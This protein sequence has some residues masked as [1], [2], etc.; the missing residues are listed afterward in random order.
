MSWENRLRGL[1]VA[2]GSAVRW[3]AGDLR[4][5]WLSALFSVAAAFVID[6]P[7]IGGSRLLREKGVKIHTL[8]S[9]EGH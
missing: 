7:D 4:A 3:L 5:H 2:I 8:V 1:A 9:F 6:L